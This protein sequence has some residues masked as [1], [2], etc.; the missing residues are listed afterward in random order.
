MKNHMQMAAERITALRRQKGMTQ[1]QLAKK[2]GVSRGCVANWENC[3][4]EPDA[5]NLLALASCFSVSIEYL[6]GRSDQRTEIKIPKVYNIDFDKLNVNGQQL[7]AHYYQYLIEKDLY[8][9]H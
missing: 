5:S 4:R 9:R 3:I 6:C 8:R 2:L 1:S 7:M